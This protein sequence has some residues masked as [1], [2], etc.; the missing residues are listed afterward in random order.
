[1]TSSCL[2]FVPQ[3]S[4]P[5]DPYDVRKLGTLPFPTQ[6]VQGTEVQAR[7]L[8]KLPLFGHLFFNTTDVFGAKRRVGHAYIC[9]RMILASQCGFEVIRPPPPKELAPPRPKMAFLLYIHIDAHRDLCEKKIGTQIYWL[10][11]F[12]LFRLFFWEVLSRRSRL[13]RTTSDSA[14]KGGNIQAKIK[15]LFSVFF[16]Q[17][18]VT[19]LSRRSRLLD[20]REQ[21]AVLPRTTSGPTRLIQPRPIDCDRVSEQTVKTFPVALH[22][23]P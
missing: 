10:W 20:F 15:L 11:Y 5:G 1:M 17:K 6:E 19:I 2:R 13:S 16:G 12:F 21:Q 3:H 14:L 7:R 18:S 4:L 8:K 23:V 22:H 9:P